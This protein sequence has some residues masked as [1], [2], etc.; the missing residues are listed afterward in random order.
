MSLFIP[1]PSTRAREA[2][3]AAARLTSGTG[4]TLT[5][6]ATP[7]ALPASPTELIAATAYDTTWI[8][9][10]LHGMATS[11]A[12]TDGLVNIYV[13]AGGSEVLFIPNLLA[14]WSGV[15][16]T[17][18]GRLYGF[19]LRIPRG[20][21]LSAN[22]RAL[23]ASD[24]VECIIELYDLNQWAGGGVECLGA[25]TA[26]SRGTDV[27]PGTTSDGTFTAIGTTGRLWRYLYPQIMGNVDV[28]LTGSG[29]V[30]LDVGTGGA[31]IADLDEFYLLNDSSEV[32]REM[33]GLGRYV[34][35][36]S[37]TALQARLQ[38]AAADAEAK[39]VC[40][41]GVY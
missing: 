39:S 19:P 25:V 13:G 41:Y 20:T 4:V 35:I 2:P 21:R 3:V 30:A 18:G 12:S 36:A 14:G 16:V 40:L 29:G 17:G 37:G 38:S 26:S 7:H 33:F 8:S 22:L 27:T 9:I 24:T 15:L 10:L 23:L 34:D 28:T 5:A 1:A 32:Q 6:S 31:A 11:A